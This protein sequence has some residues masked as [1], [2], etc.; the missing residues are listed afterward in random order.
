MNN[1]KYRIRNSNLLCLA[2]KS[3]AT[4]GLILI[5]TAATAKSKPPSFICTGGAIPV[6]TYSSLTVN[7]NCSI[8]N[9]GTVSVTGN[10]VV[11][12]TLTAQTQ[13]AFFMVGGNFTVNSGG[14]ALIGC[15]DLFCN[16]VTSNPIINGNV[17]ANNPASIEFINTLIGGNFTQNGGG[18]GLTCG[19]NLD[20]FANNLIRRNFTLSNIQT[21]Q[22]LVR[23]NSIGNNATLTSNTAT[24][25]IAVEL[26]M[27]SNNLS[28]TGNVPPPIVDGNATGGKATGQCA[29]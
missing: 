10:V 24:R 14:S 22:V 29:P 11:N 27:I 15:N 23:Q 12:G 18:G 3:I 26:N 1:F 19:N 5:A 6:G 8:S 21:C 9:P 13:G 20:L 28:C 4:L 2:L 17:T 25:T 7:G 16:G